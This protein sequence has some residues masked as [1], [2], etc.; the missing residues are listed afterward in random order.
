[1]YYKDT[2]LRELNRAW[3]WGLAVLRFLFILGIVFLLLGPSL[4]VKKTEKEAPVF[5]IA[6][7]NSASVL[8]NADSSYYLNE[9]P[10]KLTVLK[11]ELSQDFDLHYLQF[12]DSVQNK[13]TLDFTD[14][15]T[16][17]S[18]LMFSLKAGYS[19]RHVAGMLLASDGLYN[20]G[21][22][23]LHQFRN[24]PYPVFTLALADTMQKKDALIQ[25]VNYNR[26]AFLNNRF[27]VRIHYQSHKLDKKTLTIKLIKD[28]KTLIQKQVEINGD[29]VSD[30]IDIQVKAEETGL[31][32]YKLAIEPVEDEI[33]HK[34]NYQRISVN[35]IDNQQNIALIAASPHP[36]IGALNRSLKQNK[37]FSVDIFY[38]S[39]LPLNLEDTDL[40][41]CH[42]IPAK[43]NPASPIFKEAEQRHLP[44]LF[45]FG[46]QSDLHAFNQ[47]AY[48]LNI[49]KKGESMD[50]A[51]PVYEQGFKRFGLSSALL[52]MLDKLSPLY[53]PFADFN[54]TGEHDMLFSQSI[55]GIKTGKPLISLAGMEQR[56]IAYILGT[57]I[58]KWRIEEFVQNG[59]HNSFDKLINNMIQ[60]LVTKSTGQQFSVVT[61]Q[62]IPENQS[63]VFDAELYNEAFEL[64][65]EPDVMLHIQDSTGNEKE[66]KFKRSINAYRLSL[67]SMPVGKYSWRAEVGYEDNRY[68]KE[69]GFIVEAVSLEALKTRADHKLLGMI[70]NNTG[71]EMFFPENMDEI[72]ERIEAYDITKTRITTSQTHSVLLNLKWIFFLLLGLISVEWFFRKYHGGY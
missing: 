10:E 44:V 57:N 64:I 39:D 67:G 46:L 34:N 27:P 23:P 6:Q 50:Y 65:N 63:V 7:D 2:Q 26:I 16:N 37:N 68:T 13:E 43:N 8:L 25:D 41:I 12:G 24:L 18:D 51:R 54:F 42:Q 62:I 21:H 33:T 47:L 9:Y 15:V 56:K 53:V 22:H 20:Q 36:D 45:V 66:Y 17:F 49:D 52:D 55:N 30:H 31:Q 72:P 48:N 28:D 60:Y 14:P 5:I 1:L 40:I 19:G 3:I 59:N 35:V 11:K 38:L 71:A 29:Q 69:G 61:E 32:T 70:S 58:W 4:N